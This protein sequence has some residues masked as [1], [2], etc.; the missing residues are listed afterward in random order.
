MKQGIHFGNC[1]ICDKPYDSKRYRTR[2]HIF[3][4]W[5]YEDGIK[6]Y[7][8]NQCHQVEFHHW[9]PM[10]YSKPWTPN[11]CIRKWVEF[12]FIKGKDAYAIYPVLNEL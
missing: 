11:Q 5:W 10:A 2:H 12:C 3:P 6:V 1:P 4:V 8:C 7:A 9:Y